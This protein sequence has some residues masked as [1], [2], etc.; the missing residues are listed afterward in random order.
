M[1]EGD[2][3]VAL[4]KEKLTLEERLRAGEV[5]ADF[6]HSLS[7]LIALRGEIAA[8]VPTTPAGAAALARL[9]REKGKARNFEWAEVIDQIIDNLITGL[10]AM[11]RAAGFDDRGY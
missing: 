7:R 6:E 9:L 11:A 1:S 4:W 5:S 8:L 2:P 10:D 3:I